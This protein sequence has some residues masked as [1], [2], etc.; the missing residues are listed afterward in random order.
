MQKLNEDNLL[1]LN[2]AC[3]RCKSDLAL[4]IL[5]VR[6][7]LDGDKVVEQEYEINCLDCGLEF[8]WYQ[9]TGT[10]FVEG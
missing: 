3:P 5:N 10:T 7:D 2:V 4:L 6:P 8:F 1:Q 9:V